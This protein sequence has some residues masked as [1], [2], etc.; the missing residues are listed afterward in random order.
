[1]TS[2][3]RSLLQVASIHSHQQFQVQSQPQIDKESECLND[4]SENQ[5]HEYQDPTRKL[6]EDHSN[7][8]SKLTYLSYVLIAG[9]IIAAFVF[10]LDQ[11]FRDSN[12][13][14][15]V[16]IAVSNQ[17]GMPLIRLSLDLSTVNRPTSGEYSLV[18]SKIDLQSMSCQYWRNYNHQPYTFTTFFN[19]HSLFV[20]GEHKFTKSS[21]KIDNTGK[22]LHFTF[23]RYT[24]T[25]FYG[26]GSAY[27]QVTIIHYKINNVLI[28]DKMAD[29]YILSKQS[30]LFQIIKSSYNNNDNNNS[31]NVLY[32][33]DLEM[34]FNESF[35]GTARKDY[36]VLWII[37][38]FKTKKIQILNAPKDNCNINFNIIS[39]C[40][41]S[42]KKLCSNMETI[43]DKSDKYYRVAT[44]PISQFMKDGESTN[45]YTNLQLLKRSY[46]NLTYSTFTT[47][48]EITN[49]II[50]K[51]NV[52][53][54][55]E[56]LSY[57]N[58]NNSED[59][60]VNFNQNFDIYV[61]SEG[62]D[63]TYTTK[64]IITIWGV[65]ASTGGMFSL[66]STI[67]LTIFSLLTYGID[68]P[69]YFDCS[70]CCKCCICCHCCCNCKCCYKKYSLNW[71]Q[72]HMVGVARFQQFDRKERSQLE[73]FL[74]TNGYRGSNELEMIVNNKFDTLNKE[75]IQAKQEIKF[76][77]NQIMQ[78]HM[79]NENANASDDHESKVD[80]AS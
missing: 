72:K 32:V 58:V 8:G 56:I 60:I 41:N 53:V 70:K 39:T 80:H 30:P 65:I 4:D 9:G 71:C 68:I 12:A 20:S 77:R 13:T 49:K 15:E 31:N 48:N 27:S 16:N 36:G 74:N 25:V 54:D 19:N 23:A 55:N 28:D 22:I 45:Y 3:F 17:I 11:Y 66:I 26:F 10:Y 35:D 62:F 69:D 44:V 29:L 79:L 2:V 59:D 21:I 50:K 46:G 73:R 52:D 34:Q 76:L 37:P 57:F 5:Q 64:R 14:T 33:V 1:M 75:L 24:E 78:M 7:Y 67:A 47:I 51:F 38:L 42:S 6:Y 40:L 18:D 63:H 61:N 43:L